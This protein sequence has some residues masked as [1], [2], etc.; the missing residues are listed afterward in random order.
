MTVTTRTFAEADLFVNVSSLHE[1]RPEQIAIC[2]D[3]IDRHTRIRF[4]TKQ[5]QRSINV[6]DEVEV[7]REDYP[8]PAHWRVLLERDAEATPGFFEAVYRV[9]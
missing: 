5:W 3:L 2:F 1:M 9:S 4:Y 8:V 6:W 7:R